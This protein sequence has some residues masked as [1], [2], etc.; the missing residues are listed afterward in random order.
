MPSPSATLASG[1]SMR[2]LPSNRTSQQRNR[3]TTN[4]GNS[5]RSSKTQGKK[6]GNRLLYLYRHWFP[7]PLLILC[8]C[9]PHGSPDYGDRAL[10]PGGV[11]ISGIRF[12]QTPEDLRAL[13]PEAHCVRNAPETEICS[14]IPGQTDRQGGFRGVERVGCRVQ[15][16]YLRSI[17][18][19]YL[20]MLDVEFSVFDK[21]VREKYGYLPAAEGIDTLYIEWQYDSVAVSLTPNKRPHWIGQVST[22][23]PVLEF[24]KR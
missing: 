4:T 13:L 21:Q 6:R 22:Y 16:D 20:E 18:V 17:R 12:S 9:G 11:N 19:E 3:R 5:F 10:S 24:V 8:G 15:H 7:L 14:W 1:T 23:R 2:P